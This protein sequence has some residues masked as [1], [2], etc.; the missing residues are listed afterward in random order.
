MIDLVSDVEYPHATATGLRRRPVC[1]RAGRALSRQLC[2]GK[3]GRGLARDPTLLLEQLDP[4]ARLAQ[5]RVVDDGRRGLD[6]RVDASLVHPLRQRHDVDAEVGGDLLQC[7]AG[8]AVLGDAGDV[9]SV[10]AGVGLGYSDIL[11]GLLRSKPAR[12]PTI[13]AAGLES[14]PPRLSPTS[15]VGRSMRLIRYRTNGYCCIAEPVGDHD[16]W[17]P[18]RQGKVSPSE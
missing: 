17:D 12:L 3:V 10:F 11:P 18:C 7:Q 13:D 14:K 4:S 6:A 2:L 9:V 16:V 5:L 15:A 8:V 1:S